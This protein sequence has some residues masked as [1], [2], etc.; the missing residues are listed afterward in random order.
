VQ[1][2]LYCAECGLEM[3]CPPEFEDRPINCPHCLK[4][5]ME[6]TARSRADGAGLRTGANGA[7]L[8]VVVGVP[9]ALAVAVYAVGRVRAGREQGPEGEARR[10]SCPVCGHKLRS[11]VFG[12]GATAV[13]PVCAEQFVEPGDQE[14]KG[15]DADAGG[16]DVREWGEWLGSE[17]RKGARR[18]GRA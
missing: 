7:V 15:A 10:V 11:N 14:R 18:P 3:T 9:L 17:L 12:P 1:W 5:R 8:A 4:R 13:C 6:V 2:Y 16:E